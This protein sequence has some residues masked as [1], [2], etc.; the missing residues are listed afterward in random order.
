MRQ[1]GGVTNFRQE[2]TASKD[3]SRPATLLEAVPSRI[4]AVTDDL[5]TATARRIGG[6]R[7]VPLLIRIS[8]FGL[9]AISVSGIGHAVHHP[10]EDEGGEPARVVTSLVDGRATLDLVPE[11]FEAELG[12]RPVPAAGT[13]VNPHGGCSTPGGVGPDAFNTACQ[14]HDFGYDI[15]RYAEGTGT[16]IGPWARFDLDRRLY[17][18]LL[19]VCDTVTCEA[20]ATVYFTAVTLNSIRQGYVAPTTEPTIPWAG[21]FVAVVGLATATTPIKERWN[22]RTTGIPV[23]HRS[24]LR[25]LIRFQRTSSVDRLGASDLL[26]GQLATPAEQDDSLM[27]RSAPGD[28]LRPLAQTQSGAVLVERGS[29]MTSPPHGTSQRF[30]SPQLPSMSRFWHRARRQSGILRKADLPICLARSM[31]GEDVRSVHN[32]MS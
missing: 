25:S 32:P 16:R 31:P 15:L 20:T 13:L 24:W 27:N 2:P 29:I 10:V 12:Y 14:V 5:V 3:C 26:F 9:I 23:S 11:S 8:I 21:T 1:L 30:K 22:G 7:P 6:L 4:P 19:R 28:V 17:A 18:D